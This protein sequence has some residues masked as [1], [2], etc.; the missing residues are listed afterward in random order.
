M[1]S[2][3]AKEILSEIE[4]TTLKS[5]IEVKILKFRKQYIC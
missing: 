1:F 3:V 5:Q 2:Y 4:D